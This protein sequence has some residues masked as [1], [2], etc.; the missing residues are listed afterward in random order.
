MNDLQNTYCEV[1]FHGRKPTD[2]LGKSVF[3][4][5]GELKTGLTV[6]EKT[7][8]LAAEDDMPHGKISA[9]TMMSNLE[10]WLSRGYEVQVF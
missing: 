1:F 5:L 8:E 7:Y 4:I 10:L 9:V 6:C 3:K 2:R